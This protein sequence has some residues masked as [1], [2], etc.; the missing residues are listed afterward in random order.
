MDSSALIGFCDGKVIG[1]HLDRN[2]FR[3]CR[4]SYTKDLFLLG[5]EAGCFDIPSDQV[6]KR[7]SLSAGETVMVNSTNGSFSFRDPE[8]VAE[9]EEENIFNP[10]LKN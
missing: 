9:D 2:G 4:W 7:G 8:V 1:A 10:R 6:I 5:S 3:P